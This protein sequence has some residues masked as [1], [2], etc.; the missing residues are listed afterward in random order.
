MPHRGAVWFDAK[1]TN[2]SVKSIENSTLI[3]TPAM[4]DYKCYEDSALDSMFWLRL[5]LAGVRVSQ[6]G[7]KAKST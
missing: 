1:R 4:T 5:G 6:S 3:P 2:F 7:R